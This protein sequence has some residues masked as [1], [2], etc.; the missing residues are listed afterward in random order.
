MLHVCLNPFG[1][2]FVLDYFIRSYFSTYFNKLN[3][4][5]VYSLLVVVGMTITKLYA[6]FVI[7]L[8]YVSMKIRYD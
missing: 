7:L 2:E 3:D 8:Y 6:L 4:L 1:V 5:L